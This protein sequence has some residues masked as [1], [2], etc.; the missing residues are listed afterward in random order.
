M[1]DLLKPE[2]QDKLALILIY[3]VVPG[4]YMSSNL[5][6]EKLKTVNGKNLDVRTENGNI[7]VN[8]ATV[9]RKDMIAPNGVMHEIDTVLMP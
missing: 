2:N 7:K 6:N 4:K 1:N 8:N 5:S 3:H 9:L